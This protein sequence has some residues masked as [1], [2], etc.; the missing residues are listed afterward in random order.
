MGRGGCAADRLDE[1]EDLEG[2]QRGRISSF[3]RVD[4]HSDAWIHLGI[5]V[6]VS[7]A[8]PNGSLSD[9]SSRDSPGT[10]TNCAPYFIE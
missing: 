9:Q 8:R 5:R 4:H 1:R 6:A 2:G 7:K 3:E 10:F